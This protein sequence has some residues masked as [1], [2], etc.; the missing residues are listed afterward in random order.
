MNVSGGYFKALGDKDTN[1]AGHL[2]EGTASISGGYFGGNYYYS[3][4]NDLIASGHAV[5]TLTNSEPEETDAAA[6][7]SGYKYK[8]E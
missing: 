4:G 7:A 6:Y 3:L 5:R 8:V 2:V 1:S